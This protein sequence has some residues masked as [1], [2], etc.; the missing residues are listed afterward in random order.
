METS[1][2]TQRSWRI[3]KAQFQNTSMIFESLWWPGV[4]VKY[5]NYCSL[6]GEGFLSI[7][8]CL[9][10]NWSI[11]GLYKSQ[12][13]LILHFWFWCLFTYKFVAVMSRI[14]RVF[15]TVA[16]HLWAPVRSESL[17]YHL[18]LFCALFWVQIVFIVFQKFMQWRLKVFFLRQS[19]KFCLW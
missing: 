15:Q 17:F 13:R 7:A 11:R 5:S 16:T 9:G 14:E 6:L 2:S 1:V 8:S 3:D 10:L 18:W 12:A 19:T 4:K